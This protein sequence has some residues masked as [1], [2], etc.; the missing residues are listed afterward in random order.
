MT[1]KKKYLFKI[2]GLT[3]STLLLLFFCFFTQ[4]VSAWSINSNVDKSSNDADKYILSESNHS[5]LHPDNH[6]SDFSHNPLS[7][8]E[9]IPTPGE[10]IPTPGEPSE[11]ED[12]KEN[13]DD[14][15]WSK[16]SFL[17]Y[18]YFDSA[19]K[20]SNVSIAQFE[21]TVLNR[22]KVSLVVLHHSWKSFLS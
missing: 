12:N 19:I 15:E 10:P 6:Y 8:T 7:P 4:S 18:S 9:P 5:T 13:Q 20:S 3:L 16:L 22:T 17:F 2:Q 1:D 11:K 21:Q 14:D